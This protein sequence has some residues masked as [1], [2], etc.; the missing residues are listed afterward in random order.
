VIETVPATAEGTVRVCAVD[1]LAVGERRIVEIEGRATGTIG[2]FATPEGYFAIRNYCP[3]HGAPLCIGHVSGTMV[4]EDPSDP[5]YVMDGQVIKCPWHQWEFDL[6]TGRSLFDAK[7]RARAYP[8]L[9]RDGDI[10]IDLKGRV[11]DP[12][13]SPLPVSERNQVA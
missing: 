13:D 3:H 2:V 12:G 9:V 8:V 7:V 6:R 10:Y 4:A 5:D 11:A 1:E